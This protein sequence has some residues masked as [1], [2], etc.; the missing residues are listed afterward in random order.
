MAPLCLSRIYQAR[1]VL[2]RIV[3][4]PILRLVKDEVRRLEFFN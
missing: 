4:G 3:L 2:Q 1:A